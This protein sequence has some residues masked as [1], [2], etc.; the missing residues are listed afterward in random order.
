[1][2][3]MVKS[4]P[5]VALDEEG[6]HLL[7]LRFSGSEA[8]LLAVEEAEINGSSSSLVLVWLSSDTGKVGPGSLRDLKGTTSP[9]FRPL[10][11]MSQF[12]NWPRSYQ[13]D[14][15]MNEISGALCPKWSR[16]PQRLM[17]W[18]TKSKKEWKLIEIHDEIN[19]LR[20]KIYWVL[21]SKRSQLYLQM[22]KS[23]V[24]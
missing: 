13:I 24:I 18:R 5:A 19:G 14:S 3:E 20:F 9:R 15:W 1:M 12:S 8:A 21:L 17:L 4:L 23:Q 11:S 7:P 10:W 16:M 22:M 6:S 2:E